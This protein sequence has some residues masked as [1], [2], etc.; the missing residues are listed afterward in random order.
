MSAEAAYAFKGSTPF[1]VESDPKVNPAEVQRFAP[2]SRLTNLCS[3]ASAAPTKEAAQ[4]ILDAAA[5][6][7]PAIDA[8]AAAARECLADVALGLGLVDPTVA[9]EPE[10]EP[11]ADPQS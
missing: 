8:A 7:L 9:P 11:E 5:S 6:E 10:P 4:S 3:Q 1:I 2:F